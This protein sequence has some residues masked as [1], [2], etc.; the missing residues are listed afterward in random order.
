MCILD[1]EMKQ[2]SNSNSFMYL[3]RIKKI[4][5]IDTK[6]TAVCRLFFFFLLLHANGESNGIAISP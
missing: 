6:K 2:H 4:N 5:S 1:L 3:K